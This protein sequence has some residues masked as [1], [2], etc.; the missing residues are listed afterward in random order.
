[1]KQIKKRRRT[2]TRMSVKNALFIVFASAGT[3][4]A[5]MLPLAYV[6]FARGSSGIGT[7][8]GFAFTTILGVLVGVFITRP[9]YAKF[10]EIFLK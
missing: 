6:G 10:V 7:L 2:R 5:A 1:M 9:V 8:A 4:I 3:L